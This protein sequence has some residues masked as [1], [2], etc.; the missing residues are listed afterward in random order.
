MSALTSFESRVNK[1]MAIVMWYQGWGAGNAAYDPNIMQ[2]VANN[3]SVPLITW[4]PWNYADPRGVNQGNF[5]TVRIAAGDFDN[6][7]RSWAQGIKSY[8]RPVFLRFAHEMNAR[9]YPWS[10]GVNGNTSQSYVAAWQRIHGI[11]AAAGAT[12]VRWLWSPNVKYEGT[13]PFADVFPGDAYVDWIGI[14]GYNGGTALSWGG[15]Q[16]FGQIF[17]ASYHDLS[18]L[19]Q[20]PIMIAETGS[21]E[22]GGSK[23]AWITDAML[24]QLP[25]NFPRVRAFVWFNENRAGEA[26]W[27]IESSAGALAAYAQAAANPNFR[28]T[29]S[30]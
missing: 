22:P 8:G 7:V 30:P 29:I 15:W 28:S 19:S 20:K 25:Q 9:S 6:Y 12:N 23:A 4:E 14:D 26:D 16:P 13:T 21:V 10:I 11:F 18:R 5:S 2:A 24:T 27:R 17:A 1:K 3:G